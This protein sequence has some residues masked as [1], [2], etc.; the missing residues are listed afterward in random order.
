MSATSAAV[1]A[2]GAVHANP[3]IGETMIVHPRRPGDRVLRVELHVEGVHH[4]PTP[5]VHPQAAETFT[6]L[7][8]ELRIRLGWRRR[9]LRAGESVAVPPGVIHAYAGVPGRA[10]RV[11]VELEPPGR[12]EEFFASVYGLPA[13]ARDP[14]TGQ[15]T[16][17][18]VAGILL[19]HTDDVAVPLVP[20]ALTR[21]LLARLARRG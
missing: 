16:L 20:P 6:V 3:T 7:E 4:G 11:L 10:A 21:R 13:S 14:R 15:P 1:P 9:I 2:G 5:H 12:M 18:A 17:P 8:G 19:E